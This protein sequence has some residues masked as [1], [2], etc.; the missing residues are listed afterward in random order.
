MES[1]AQ[2]YVTGKVGVLPSG[3]K[4]RR[5]QPGGM[6]EPLTGHGVRRREKCLKRLFIALVVRSMSDI[7]SSGNRC[8][9]HWN[10]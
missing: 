9:A 8:T 6:N 2:E 3:A 5:M 10:V 1:L 4:M 7:E